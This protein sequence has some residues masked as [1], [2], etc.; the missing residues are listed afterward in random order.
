MFLLAVLDSAGIPL[1]TGVDALIVATSAASPASAVLVSVLAVAGSLLGNLVLF[2]IA[3][4]G[5][6][7]YLES[8]LRGERTKRFHAWFQ[9]YG[10]LTVFIPALVPIPLPMKI[11]VIS[12]GALGI[13]LTHFLCVVLL[14]RAPRYAALAYVGAQVGEHSLS[15]LR[16]HA[17]HL[18]LFAA[19][20][21]LFLVL[22]INVVD[23][24]RNQ[25]R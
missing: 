8:H 7:R 9:R 20:L 25:N 15:Y 3:R 13:R 17:A 5:G 6:R 12:A 24:L 19:A 23:R 2:S 16:D 4:A 18:L 1:P 10:L 21:A 14:A 11:F 22:L